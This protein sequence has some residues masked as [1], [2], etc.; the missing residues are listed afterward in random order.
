MN[1]TTKLIPN[2]MPSMDGWKASRKTTTTSFTICNTGKSIETSDCFFQ[3]I[4]LL[5]WTKKLENIVFQMK[6]CL[7]LLNFGKI[8]PTFLLWENRN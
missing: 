8:L 1:I 4:W 6:V 3:Q 2:M 5:F 7:I